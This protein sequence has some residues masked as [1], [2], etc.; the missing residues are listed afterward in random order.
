MKLNQSV[1]IA[2]VETLSVQAMQKT[3]RGRTRILQR[4]IHDYS[5]ENKFPLQQLLLT[6]LCAQS[7]TLYT[8]LRV[9]RTRSPME[10]P[11]RLVRSEPLETGLSPLTSKTASHCKIH[12]TDISK[13]ELTFT[14]RTRTWAEPQQHTSE[15]RG[16]PPI[17]PYS[18]LVN[19]HTP[20]S[21]AL[22]VLNPS[23]ARRQLT[24][25]VQSPPWVLADEA[26]FDDG[27][28][29]S[30]FLPPIAP[31]L[32]APPASPLSYYTHPNLH[33][34]SEK[35]KMLSGKP[36]LHGQHSGNT[37]ADLQCALRCPE[38]CLCSSETVSLCWLAT[39]RTRPMLRSRT[40]PCRPRRRS[41]PRRPVSCRYASVVF[42]RGT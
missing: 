2:F 27:S 22:T 30:R 35:D 16:L 25:S 42:G 21:M 1:T 34:S 28:N 41:Y 5:R 15:H 14:V 13:H 6:S 8:F 32:A 29:A 40:E 33:P 38:C 36:F 31:M 23:T 20:Q 24:K 26:S 18:P 3:F 4:L 17:R 9:N 7:V 39:R 10:S 19:Y 11:E 37:D 12:T